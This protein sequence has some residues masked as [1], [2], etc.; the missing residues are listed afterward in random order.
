M[1]HFF[2]YQETVSDNG[3][4]LTF[5]GLFTQEFIIKLGD[6]LRSKL[7]IFSV[8]RSLELKVFSLVVE[9]SQNIIFYSAEKSVQISEQHQNMGVGTITVGFKDNHFFVFCGNRITNQK[10]D[11]L[12]QNLTLLQKMN[13]D[14]LK[15]HYKAQRRITPD[16]E[17]RGA[18]LG[19]IEMARKVSQTIE[20]DFFK[21]D[22][23]YS[24][25]SIKAVI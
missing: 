6:A 8:D 18:G 14:E 23:Y 12:R 9:Q 7:S 19:F 11:K 22:E 13:K 4:F 21:L 17:S 15:E 5:S 3:I 10:V 20:F 2:D 1:N 16:A 24:Y 25:F